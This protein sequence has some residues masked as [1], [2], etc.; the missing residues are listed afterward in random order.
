MINIGNEWIIC[1]MV[2]RTEEAPRAMGKKVG[3]N[4]HEQ[5][6]GKLDIIQEAKDDLFGNSMPVGNSP[7]FN[8]SIIITI[9]NEKNV[10]DEEY[11][12]FGMPSSIS[13]SSSEEEEVQMDELSIG[14]KRSQM[15]ND[16]N[17][18]DDDDDEMDDYVGMLF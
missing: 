3:V 8:P 9:N 5:F 1:L 2:S 7:E 12:L 14:E 16:D 6:P 18:D 15:G 10:D 13:S 17:D 11:R 4:D